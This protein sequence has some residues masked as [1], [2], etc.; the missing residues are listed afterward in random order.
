MTECVIL[1]GGGCEL[2]CSRLSEKTGMGKKKVVIM[3]MRAK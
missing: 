3:E 2:L 1:G